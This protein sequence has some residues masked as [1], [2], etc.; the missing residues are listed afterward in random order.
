MLCVFNYCDA[1]IVPSSRSLSTPTVR[2]N[3]FSG[4]TIG[5]QRNQRALQ[6]RLRRPLLSEDDMA[7]PPDNRVIKAVED[8]GGND[9]LASDVAAKAGVSL[10]EASQALSSLAALS[11]A[12]ISVSSSGDLLYTFPSQLQSSLTSNSLRYKV[13]KTWDTQ[14]WP[15]LFWAIRAGF[16]LFLFI[17]IAAIF[18]TLFFIQSGSSDDR[19]D[20]RDN[21]GGGFG[22]YGMG[23]FMLDLFYPRSMFSPYYGY[24]GR[25]DPY[26]VQQVQE[27]DVNQRGRGGREEEE[28]SGIL[29]GVFSY[30]FGDG[31]PNRNVE[32]ARLQ[33]A[34][35]VIRE[36]GGSVIAEQLAPFCNVEDPNE[37]EGRFGV[38][39]S[40]VLPIVSQLGGIPSVTEDGDIIYSFPD[41]QVSSND[42]EVAFTEKLE[43]QRLEFN[44]NGA[45]GNALAGALG[46]INLGGALY[47]G[48]V[49]SSPALVGVRLP[50][51][52]GLVQ[53]G[54]PLLVVYAILFNVIP[55]ARNIYNGKLNNEIEQRNS[56]RRKWLT[57]L[58]VGGGSLKRK[59]AAAKA[60]G[61]K[62]R[63][64]GGNV[65]R[66]YD[67]TTGVD[68]LTKKRESMDMAAFD[69]LLDENDA[70]Q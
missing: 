43:E 31:D 20:R 24:Y 6:L 3:T 18:S 14:V 45:V 50:A 70:F 7:Q 32:V 4:Q 33:S 67:T 16:G 27:V 12:S 15:K 39:E 59:L 2:D 28:R 60:R 11:Q 58:K 44:R 19:D 29:E 10:N 23:N 46:A 25:Y 53:S 66:V 65:D 57:Y 5:I 47:L 1:F 55:L 22:G 62:M 56:A 40:Y 8:I 52:F 61:Q 36:N 49:L 41:L 34:A 30:I 35:Q 51:W 63:R 68:E 13:T 26:Q 54:Y 21:R 64:L 42:Y 69:K 48:Q 9:I 38:D 17:S 37:M